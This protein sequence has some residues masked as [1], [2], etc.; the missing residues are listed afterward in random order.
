[1]ISRVSNKLPSELLSLAQCLKKRSLLSHSRA[2]VAFSM[3]YDLLWKFCA[4][5][6][7]PAS[8]AKA[9]MAAA[10]PNW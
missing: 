3:A 6:A 9:E 4:R 10:S 1:M 7:F 5:Y 2:C 8:A